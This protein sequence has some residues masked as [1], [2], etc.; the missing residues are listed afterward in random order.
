MFGV[1]GVIKA[2][3]A[4]IIVV[5]IA[6]GLWYVSTIKADLAVSQMNNKLLQDGIKAQQELMEQ[7]RKDIALIQSINEDLR[8]ENEKRKQDVETLSSKFSKRDFGALAAERPAAIERLINRG[9]Q[10]AARCFELASGAP[11]N[12]KELNAKTPTEANRECPS[13]INPAY[14]SPN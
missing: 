1:T 13:L 12:E 11:L 6:G 8:Q 3:V 7:M 14:S 10:N 5:L 2:I 4:L 9:T